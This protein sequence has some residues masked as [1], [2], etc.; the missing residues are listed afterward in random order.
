MK[1]NLMLCIFACILMLTI[2]T[3]TAYGAEAFSITSYDIDITVY[4]NNSYA[5]IETINVRFIEQRHGII[6]SLPLRTNRGKPALISHID[7]FEH[8]FSTEKVSNNIE[9]KIGDPDKYASFSERYTI[10][11]VYTI[12]DD[13]L[14]D[15]DELYWNLI[16]ND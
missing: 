1:R 16:G 13:Y 8:K 4:E 6:R 15:R 11:Y 7:V 12:G 2:V 14:N 3:E 5:V 9:I 10:G